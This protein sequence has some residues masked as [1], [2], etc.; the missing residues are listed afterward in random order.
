MKYYVILETSLP[1]AILNISTPIHKTY[2]LIKGLNHKLNNYMQKQYFVCHVKLKLFQLLVS[3]YF[4][5]KTPFG[6]E[7]D[8]YK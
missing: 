6:R 3:Y 2:M 4:H 5:Q 7:S 1:K 8:L